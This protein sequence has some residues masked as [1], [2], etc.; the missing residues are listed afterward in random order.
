MERKEIENKKELK[1]LQEEIL[2]LND[3]I[4]TLQRPR[5]NQHDSQHDSQH[6][7]ATDLLQHDHDHNHNQDQYLK[8][9]EEENMKLRGLYEA[10]QQKSR[11]ISSVA[12][13]TKLTNLHKLEELS[14]QVS[15]LSIEKDQAELQ[16]TEL[17]ADRD[18][19]QKQLKN[20]NCGLEAIKKEKLE[21]EEE[22]VKLE[23]AHSQTCQN[24]EENLAQ[25]QSARVELEDLSGL[26]AISESQLSA[27]QQRIQELTLQLN[28]AKQDSGVLETKLVQKSE[29]LERLQSSLSDGS[30]ERLK[31]LSKQLADAHILACQHEQTIGTLQSHNLQLES[32]NTRLKLELENERRELA[33]V[34]QKFS[35]LRHEFQKLLP[36]LQLSLQSAFDSCQTIIE[37]LIKTF[38]C[39]E[40]QNLTGEELESVKSRFEDLKKK[41]NN[42]IKPTIMLSS[43]D[44]VDCCATAS[45][46]DYASRLVDML[47]ELRGLDEEL[48]FVFDRSRE[49]Y[50]NLKS[51]AENTRLEYASKFDSLQTDKQQI[52]AQLEMA[53]E[54]NQSLLE[55]LKTYF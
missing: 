52:E 31:D 28:A 35:L 51:V 11:R 24:Y 48:E 14:N 54:D 33:E 39:W 1:S 16:C 25:L 10:V 6:D 21:L 9:L 12:E 49:I 13:E 22:L 30:Q 36:S 41:L 53:Q 45:V 8:L 2:Q 40:N 18:K 34:W 29:E 46:K 43:S 32:E 55:Q 19:L 37:Y 38:V 15:K 27:C 3:L 42:L 5:D 4:E 17:T 47:Q 7:K 23:N 20:L 50:N 26:A 44:N